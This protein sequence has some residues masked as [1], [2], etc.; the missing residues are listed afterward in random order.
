MKV[1]G[2]VKY[3]VVIVAVLVDDS[4]YAA[5]ADCSTAVVVALLWSWRIA[6]VTQL[7]SLSFWSCEILL[8]SRS[9]LIFFQA[10][11]ICLRLL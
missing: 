4:D 8:F 6:R 5:V 2:R 7:I 10:F 3:D 1:L 9:R 11:S